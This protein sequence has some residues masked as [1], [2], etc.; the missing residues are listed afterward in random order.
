MKSFLTFLWQFDEVNF[1]DS[2]FR[3]DDDAIRIDAS[4]SGVFVF[5]AVNRFEVFGERGSCER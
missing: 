1:R 3:F 4:D 2:R 5:F